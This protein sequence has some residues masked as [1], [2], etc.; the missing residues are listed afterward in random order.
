MNMNMSYASPHSFQETQNWWA[1]IRCSQCQQAK[2]EAQVAVLETR[3]C[4]PGPPGPVITRVFAYGAAYDNERN[5]DS[6][7]IGPGA[8]LKYNIYSTSIRLT[9]DP[10][11]IVNIEESGDY[12]IKF[13]ASIS[14][15]IPVNVY[16]G[17]ELNGE[18]VLP[19][20]TK[21]RMP[22]AINIPTAYTVAGQVILSLTAGDQLKLI[23]PEF[24]PEPIFLIFTSQAANQPSFHT[25]LSVEK[26]N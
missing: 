6:V 26:L 20:V 25:T 16:V 11:Q 22:G 15:V 4:P 3:P 5:N 10:N 2:Q 9:V 8:A 7:I 23:V 19:S 14:Q 18:P 1:L 24:A 12:L 17:L 21:V 13:T